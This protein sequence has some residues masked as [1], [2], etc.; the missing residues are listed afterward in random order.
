M[1]YIVEQLNPVLYSRRLQ[2]PIAKQ[3]LIL[4]LPFADA[5]LLYRCNFQTCLIT[6]L[7]EIIIKAL[8][9]KFNCKM[10]PGTITPEFSSYRE[11]FSSEQV[12]IN[13]S[14]W[15]IKL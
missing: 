13:Y 4:M 9:I 10:Q 2:M 3:Q 14:E 12:R 11:W 15:L 1:D 8:I 6:T 5:V 7:K